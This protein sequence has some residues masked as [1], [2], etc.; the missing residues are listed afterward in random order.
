MYS[1]IFSKDARKFIE[2]QTPQTKQRIRNALLQLAEDP[3]SNRQVKR[4][5]GTEDI[6]RLRVGDL[7]VVFSIE[8]EKLA[9]LVISIGS[10][11]D[12]YNRL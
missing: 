6:L 8:D 4:L 2:K 7:R 9:I 3:F 11:G 1:L 12:I 10:R 5:K